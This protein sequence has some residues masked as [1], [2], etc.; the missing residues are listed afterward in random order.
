MRRGLEG[1]SWGREVGASS[2]IVVFGEL[3]KLLQPPAAP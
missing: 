3:T 1:E 2:S